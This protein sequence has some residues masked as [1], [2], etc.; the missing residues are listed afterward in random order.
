MAVLFALIHFAPVEYAGLFVFALAVGACA[1]FTD[2]LSCPIFVQ[3]GFNA[4]GLLMALYEWSLLNALNH[5]P[6]QARTLRTG[7]TNR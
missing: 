2:G 5:G 1:A 6:G 4:T 7:W 3:V